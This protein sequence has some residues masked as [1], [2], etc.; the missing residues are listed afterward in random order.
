MVESLD[1]VL[2]AVKIQEIR[3]PDE[4]SRAVLAA[5]RPT[6]ASV[7]RALKPAFRELQAQPKP[8]NGEV[9]STAAVREPRRAATGE[10]AGRDG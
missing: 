6:F 1:V 5:L 9:P 10:G 3:E 8:G 2:G 4:N 7:Y